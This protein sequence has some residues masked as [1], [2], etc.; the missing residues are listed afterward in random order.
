[1]EIQ[2]IVEND[3]YLVKNTKVHINVYDTNNHKYVSKIKKF[4]PEILDR[5][6][7]EQRFIENK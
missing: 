7:F 3:K 6:H 1:L 5:I 4:Y 2:K